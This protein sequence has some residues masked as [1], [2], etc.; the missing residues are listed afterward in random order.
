MSAILTII[1]GHIVLCGAQSPSIHND[2]VGIRKI[3]AETTE[4]FNRHDAKAF[5]RYYTRDAELVT[6]RGERMKGAAEIE[7]G[8]AKIFATRAKGVTL[9]TLDISV[10]FIKPDVA[11]AHVTNELSGLASAAGELLPPHLE[12][13][14]RVLV[15]DQGR[16]LVTA[17]HNTIVRPVE[18]PTP[19]PVTPT[20]ETERNRDVV[21]RHLELI[22]RGE[23]RQAAE[24]FAPDVHHHLGTWRQGSEVIVTGQKILTDNLEDI[25]RT[26]PD[27]KMDIVEMVAEGESVVV[28]CRVSGT[29]RGVGAKRINGGF[30]VGVQPSGKRFEVQHIHWYK[31]R[32]GKITDH[33]T[34]RDDL[35][36]TQQLGLLPSG[37]R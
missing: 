31:L 7:K 17:F 10:R 19:V 29:H 5:T 33:F 16:W 6:V 11:V 1:V 2:E 36:M 32:D 15:K 14:I 25:F 13:S 28:R 37:N 21:R 34:N 9:K 8:L 12:L 30:L 18:P 20:S 3:I 23:W 22:N 27:W 35:G 24:M 26:F 4:A